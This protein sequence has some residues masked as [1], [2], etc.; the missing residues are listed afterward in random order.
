MS[1]RGFTR[2][3]GYRPRGNDFRVKEE[4]LILDVRKQS[5]TQKLVRHWD[6][7]PRQ[8]LNTPCVFKTKLDGAPK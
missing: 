2:Q 3:D 5:F 6:R 7:L 4:R 8:V 1:A